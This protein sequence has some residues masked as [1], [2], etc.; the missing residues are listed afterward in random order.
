MTAEE[1]KDISRY[2]RLVGYRDDG[3]ILLDEYEELEDIIKK[4][5]IARLLENA[6][7]Q[8]IVGKISEEQY[9]KMEKKYIDEIYG[10]KIDV[11]VG[12]KDL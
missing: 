2:F 7:Y 12:K 5:T 10:K 1:K 9:Q 3:D 11:I 4:S 8:C 6:R